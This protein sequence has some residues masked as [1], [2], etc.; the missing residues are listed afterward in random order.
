MDGRRLGLVVGC[1]VGHLEG[2]SDGTLVGFANNKNT[3][4]GQEKNKSP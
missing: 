3:N 2:L 4:V 1:D